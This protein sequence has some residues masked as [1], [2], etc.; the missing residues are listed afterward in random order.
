MCVFFHTNLIFA[1]G[2]GSLLSLLGRWSTV[3]R[4]T[5][6]GG[7]SSH[8]R[9]IHGCSALN[10]ASDGLPRERGSAFS[11]DNRHSTI[12]SRSPAV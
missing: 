5:A 4:H 8:L 9:L 1:P 12:S 11:S 6:V 3:S 10:D 7:L 2:T